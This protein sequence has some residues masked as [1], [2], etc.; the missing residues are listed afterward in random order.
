MPNSEI[1][2]RGAISEDETLMTFPPD[3]RFKTGYDADSD[4]YDVVGND[5][6]GIVDDRTMSLDPLAGSSSSTHPGVLAASRD[7]VIGDT[8]T[9]TYNL[10]AAHIA[11]LGV[12]GLNVDNL[13]VAAQV[14]EIE[15]GVTT[16]D[17]AFLAYFGAGATATLVNALFGC[18]SV[19]TGVNTGANF[20]IDLTA[21][22]LKIIKAAA[23]LDNDVCIMTGAG[24]P[25]DGT[26]GDNY[27]GPGSL[28]IDITNK[29]AYIQSSLITTPVWKII[30]SA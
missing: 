12:L 23:R 22:N 6:V 16:G 1:F 15:N 10:V 8:L 3:M 25:T 11:S 27:A 26:T 17:A 9:A 30:T 5:T 24:A 19:N 28:Y 21:A 29:K 2:P 7:R 4:P 20:G 18:A 14:A 13:P